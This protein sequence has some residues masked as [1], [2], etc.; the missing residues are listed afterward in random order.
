MHHHR[1]VSSGDSPYII[2]AV[3]SGDSVYN[4]SSRIG[5]LKVINQP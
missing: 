1:D 4:G 5:L 2:K 3:Y